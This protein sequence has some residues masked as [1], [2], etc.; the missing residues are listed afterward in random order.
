MAAADPPS[1]AEREFLALCADPEAF[2]AWS[3][4]V[5]HAW[6]RARYG[7]ERYAAWCRAVE[8][9]RKEELERQKQQQQRYPR[10]SW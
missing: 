6:M 5:L 3:D 8:I 2:K 9:A 4:E 1:P 10:R 7:E